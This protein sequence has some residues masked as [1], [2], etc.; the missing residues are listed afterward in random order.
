[1]CSVR[2]H[3]SGIFGQTDFDCPGEAVL[4]LRP[5]ADVQVVQGAHAGR[6]TPKDL[7]SDSVLVFTDICPLEADE[8]VIKGARQVVVLDHHPTTEE[9]VKPL[10]DKF[11]EKINDLSMNDGKCCGAV[12]AQQ[13]CEGVYAMDPDTLH[14]FHKLD[15]FRHSLPSHLEPLLNPFK[16][17]INQKGT[18]EC[19]LSLV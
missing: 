1:M 18:R 10:K 4:A 8:N 17:W 13:F 7:A 14:L 6:I 12:L 11:G 15:V 2:S 19:D 3:R 9:Q 16:G 5:G